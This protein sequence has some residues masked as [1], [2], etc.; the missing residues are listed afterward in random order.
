MVRAKSNDR[1]GKL[2]FRARTFLRLV[3]PCMLDDTSSTQYTVPTSVPFMI[4][5]HERNST[6]AKRKAYRSHCGSGDGIHS[7]A[8]EL[9]CIKNIRQL[10]RW[11]LA[12]QGRP[13]A[14]EQIWWYQL[15]SIGHVRTKVRSKSTLPTLEYLPTLP[16]RGVACLAPILLASH[17]GQRVSES[18]GL[19]TKVS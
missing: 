16:Y 18:E 12:C 2:L 19:T 6:T 13:I 10:S 14:D 15:N 1:Q 17:F 7:I 9:C 5:S 4:C 3:E 11:L 8:D